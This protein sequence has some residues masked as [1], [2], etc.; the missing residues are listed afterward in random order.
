MCLSYRSY[1]VVAGYGRDFL[2]VYKK[3]HK[4]EKTQTE[5]PWLSQMSVALAEITWQTMIDA[6]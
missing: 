1:E 6:L 4:R 2:K 3:R 5:A